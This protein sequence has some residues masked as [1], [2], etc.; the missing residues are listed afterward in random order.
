M[1][2]P[3]TLMSDP[4]VVRGN[5]NALAR[6]VSKARQEDNHNTK[7]DNLR[8]RLE[9]A[10]E[11]P[12][13]S[14]P[15]Y[16]FVTKPFADNEVDVMKYLVESDEY[17]VQK[18]EV[19][20]QADDFN[21]AL[22][23]VTFI[24]RKTGI[25]QY[26]QVED[27]GEIF[28]FDLEV[29]PMLEV[30]VRKTME[31]A[32][33]EVEYEEELKSLQAEVARYETQMDNEAKWMHEQEEHIKRNQESIRTQLQSVL[34]VKQSERDVKTRV[35]GLQMMQQI[36]PDM[37][38]NITKSNI[39]EGIWQLPDRVN[40]EKNIIPEL[41]QDVC[42]NVAALSVSNEIIDGTSYSKFVCFRV[43]MLNF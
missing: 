32:L 21:P 34:A 30:I 10:E 25:D 22:P 6:K 33:M 40:L 2:A 12:S 28:V 42:R 14:M 36:L 13:S 9:H 35:A 27:V 18:R 39:K 19:E 3:L 26:T 29:A 37:I 31:Q 38:E 15:Y 11:L 43:P 41:L 5:T 20:T 4:R 1:G 8:L 24:P 23:P 16:N 7:S 17:V